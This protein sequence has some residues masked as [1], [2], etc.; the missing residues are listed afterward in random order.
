METAKKKRYINVVLNVP[1]NQ[2]FTYREPDE[3]EKFKTPENPFG[4]RVEINFGIRKTTGIVTGVYDEIPKS[5]SVTDDKI[6]N[7]LW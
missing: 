3:S 1:L 2:A 6:R 4:Y 5:C 7:A